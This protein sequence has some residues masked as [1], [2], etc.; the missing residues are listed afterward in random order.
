LNNGDSEERGSD[1]AQEFLTKRELTG[2]I[3]ELKIGMEKEMEEQRQV[4]LIR[5]SFC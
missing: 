5:G 3:T 2:E 4:C 1:L